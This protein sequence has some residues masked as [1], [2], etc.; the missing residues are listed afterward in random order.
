MTCI[1][2][3]VVMPTTRRFCRVYI[4]S[5]FELNC[6]RNLPRS[7]GYTVSACLYVRFKG[8]FFS[9]RCTCFLYSFDDRDC[10]MSK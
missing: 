1:Y 8:I 7:T 3:A 5:L 9:L 4:I 10:K 2:T 6:F